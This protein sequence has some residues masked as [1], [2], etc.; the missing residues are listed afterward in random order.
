MS[1]PEFHPISEILEEIQNGR[2]V[3]VVDDGDRENEG[4]LVMAASFVTPEHINFMATYGRGIICVPV[5]GRVVERL[6]LHPMVT[7][8]EDPMKTAWTISIDAKRGVTT[9][10][11]AYDR[12]HTIQVLIN[13]Q[14]TSGELTRPGHVF[15]LR[16]KDGGVLRR[17]GHTEAAVDLARLA[18][19]VPAGVIC[20]I[21]KD[22]G[23]MARTDDLFAFAKRH[24][25]KICTIAS[26]IEYRRRF[27][28]L[29]KRAVTT[30]LPTEAGEFTLISYETSIDDRQ[31]IALVKG[32]VDDGKPV[33][34][35]VHSQCLT[36]DVFAS[37]RCDCGP[38]L[39][40]AM[41]Q[42]A[43]AGRG[44]ILYINQEGRG[45]GLANKLKAYALQDEGLDT[46]EAN[47][48]LGFGADL[49]DYGIGAQILVDLGLRDLRLLTNNPRKIVGLEGYGLRVVERVPIAIAPLPE[50]MK[51]LETKREKLGHWLAD[52]E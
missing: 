52:T 14:T 31:H 10:I 27:E 20:E 41:E 11:S 26:L 16:A 21:M 2:L 7:P 32:P 18:G 40:R 44:V 23:T 46:V 29:I 15:P 4:D 33:L 45:I 24:G 48:A 38:Q 50:N 5:E 25:L 47:L 8:S 39:R 3:I 34:V 51:Y 35:R 22:D 1:Q 42:I 30:K 28:K 43:E 37:L 19:L 36:G 13:P 12:A 17:A 9:G 49:R 6:S